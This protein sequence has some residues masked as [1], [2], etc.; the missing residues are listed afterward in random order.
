MKWKW[1]ALFVLVALSALSCKRR[2][3]R[4]PFVNVNFTINLQLPQFQKLLVPANSEYLTGG[5]MGIVV[6]RVSETQFNAFDRHSTYNVSDR[7]RATLEEDGFTLK[8][9]CSESRWN[10]IDGSI[11]NGPTNAPL[12]AYSTTWNPPFLTITN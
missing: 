4:I 2:D 6:Y 8:D 3:N 12:Q 11:I 7:C 10:I 5:S 9:E 1:S